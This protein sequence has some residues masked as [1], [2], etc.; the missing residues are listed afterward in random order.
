[1]LPLA[2]IG[3]GRAADNLAGRLPEL[4]RDAGFT[5]LRETARFHT[6]FA[7][8]IFLLA[9]HYLTTGLGRLSTWI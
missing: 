2:S 8:P 3:E 4:V 7:I 5:E 6:L 9:K 1:M